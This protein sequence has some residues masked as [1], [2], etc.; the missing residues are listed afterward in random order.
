MHLMNFLLRAETPE[1]MLKEAREVQE[2]MVVMVVVDPLGAVVVEEAL[3]ALLEIREQ[4]F[5][6]R[7]PREQMEP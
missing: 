6:T 7:H 3:Q 5:L 2:V 1:Q 4:P